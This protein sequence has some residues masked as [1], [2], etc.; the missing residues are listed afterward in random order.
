MQPGSADGAPPE[1]RPRSRPRTVGAA[2]AAVAILLLV[3]RLGPSSPANP[4]FTAD[5]RARPIPEAQL[6]PTTLNEFEG[7]LV[8]L[9]GQPVIVNIWA[10]WCAP[11]RAE[12]P[13]LQ[14][15]AE[16]Y[17]GEVTVLGVDSRDS[18]G[19][20]ANFLDDVGI[21]YPNVFD[22]TGAIRKALGL[23]G[24]PTTYFIDSEGEIVATVVGGI[25]EAR[26]A[27]QLEA[28]R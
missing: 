24:F 11:C 28:M 7:I 19:P 9:R 6:E 14:R 22:Q 10:S 21:D 3:L 18:T 1:P 26:L 4:E 8:G 27:A 12:M 2:V 25:T 23:R 15:A 20:A 17:V 13:L 5:G 16:E